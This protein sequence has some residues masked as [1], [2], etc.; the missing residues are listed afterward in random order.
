VRQKGAVCFMR[1]EKLT[2]IAVIL[3]M[4]YTS[5]G[6]ANVAISTNSPYFPSVWQGALQFTG[7]VA[8]DAGS[9]FVLTLQSDGRVTNWVAGFP[10][11]TAP[12]GLSDV[13]AISASFVTAM[14]L[15]SGGTVVAWGQGSQTNVPD[16]L[17]NIVAISA[18]NYSDLALRADGTVISWGTS[19]TV[20]A[21]LSNVVA[22]AAGSGFLA[23]EANG[24][25]VS[26]GYSYSPPAGLSNVI[27]ISI[28]QYQ[29]S[30][31]VEGSVALLADG[32]VIGWDSAGVYT[33]LL[34]SDI[35]NTVAVSGAPNAFL[36][37]RADGSLVVGGTPPLISFPEKLTNVFWLGKLSFDNAVVVQG[38]SSPVLTV[39]PGNQTTGVGGTIYLHARA[40]GTQ[41][42]S[43]QWQ[44]NGT[45]LPG[46]T[47]GDLIITNATAANDGLY[48]TLVTSEVID[49]GSAFSSVATVTVAS[50]TVYVPAH[51]TA[52]LLQPDGSLIIN[53]SANGA[54]FPLA[55]TA[56]F[57]IQ[58]STDL[59]HWTSL[60]NGLSLTNGAIE[61]ID[62]FSATGP[63]G[64]YRLL[65][66]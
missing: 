42:I 57:N 31:G 59:V 55:N 29:I 41:P 11:M 35:T 39:Q 6:R 64:F 12:P 33:N 26:W 62:P 58:A 38:L 14:A 60:T 3:G 27:A 46:A 8:A 45:N 21:G 50:P 13:T 20:P 32:K 49:G 53:V 52:P 5:T 47:S 25:V 34:A 18:G 1:M 37:L 54:A 66:Q 56:L 48:Q 51:L 43:Y 30:G 15:T 61:L 19:T 10:E 28:G 7:V 40:V 65:R 44:F 22:I 63:A 17:S 36:A 16:G 4:V 9:S 2:F 23:L 24:T